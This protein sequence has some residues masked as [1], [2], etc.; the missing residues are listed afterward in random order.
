MTTAQLEHKDEHQPFLYL[1]SNAVVD[2]FKK[3][4]LLVT[5]FVAGMLLLVR[6]TGVNGFLQILRSEAV[7][8][9]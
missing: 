7:S 3:M 5:L 2:M 4:I 1:S 6:K 9:V 8:K